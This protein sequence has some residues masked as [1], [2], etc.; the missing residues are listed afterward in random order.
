VLMSRD[1]LVKGGIQVVQLR[2][3]AVTV[4]R[5]LMPVAQPEEHCSNPV[6]TKRMPRQDEPLSHVPA[7]GAKRAYAANGRSTCVSLLFD[8]YAT[9]CCVLSRRTL[10]DHGQQEIVIIMMSDPKKISLSIDEIF[11]RFVADPN[12]ITSVF[13]VFS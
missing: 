1:L 5:W 2:A 7:G 8:Q 10:R 4:V 6:A 11:L 13:L 9:S 12:H 3:S